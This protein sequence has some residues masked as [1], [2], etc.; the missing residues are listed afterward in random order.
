MICIQYIQHLRGSL[1]QYLGA[2]WGVAN[3]N[4]NFEVNKLATLND[5]IVN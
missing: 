4:H 2:K 5:L 1:T 3:D